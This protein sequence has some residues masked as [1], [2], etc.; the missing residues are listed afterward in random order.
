[1]HIDIVY[2]DV[3]EINYLSF[4]TSTL[5]IKGSTPALIGNASLSVAYMHH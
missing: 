5:T 3:L 2:D 4:S 1:M